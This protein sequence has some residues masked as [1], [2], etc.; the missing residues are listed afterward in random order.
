VGLLVSEAQ[1]TSIVQKDWVEL[2]WDWGWVGT[3]QV[4]NL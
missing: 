1:L 4:M 3:V 2:E